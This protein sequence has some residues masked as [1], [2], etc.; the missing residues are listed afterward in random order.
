MRRQC[1][2]VDGDK[3]EPPAPRRRHLLHGGELLRPSPLARAAAEPSP[4]EWSTF[5]FDAVIVVAAAGVEV[6]AGLPPSHPLHPTPQNFSYR[7]PTAAS[8]FLD[9][10]I[11]IAKSIP[12][13]DSRAPTITVEDRKSVV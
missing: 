5:L 3:A 13:E 6:V 4:P 8:S 9:R 1:D 11:Q 12:D 10:Q 2:N 7:I